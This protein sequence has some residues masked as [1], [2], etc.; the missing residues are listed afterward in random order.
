MKKK[1]D[2]RVGE[3][4]W[5]AAENGSSSYRCLVMVSAYFFVSDTNRSIFGNPQDRAPAKKNLLDGHFH[6]KI[7]QLVA[8]LQARPELTKGFWLALP[9]KGI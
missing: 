9:H 1:E 3:R 4:K 2:H 7:L 5:H 6:E 8:A